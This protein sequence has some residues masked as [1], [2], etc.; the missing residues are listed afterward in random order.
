M[1]VTDAAVRW[2]LDLGEPALAL[3]PLPGAVAVAGTEGAVAVIGLD[4]AERLRLQ[5]DDLP[6]AL[7]ASPDGSRLALGGA[8]RLVVWEL[9]TGGRLR[10][11]SAR[12]CA[13]LAWAARSDRLAAGDGRRVRVHDRDGRPVWASDPLAST[14]AGLAWLWADGRRLAAAAYQGVTLLEP[15][16]GR[17]VEHLRAPGAIAGLA[18]APPRGRWVVGGSQDATLHGWKV[19][20]GDD[21]R[22]SGFPATV[23]R[24]AFHGDGRW[25]ACESRE[26]V[27][28]WDF[29]GRGPVGREA[30]V[31]VGHRS[32]IIALVWAPDAPTLLTV[33]EAGGLAVWRLG[34]AVR[35]GGR[36]RPAREVETAGEASAVAV[37]GGLVVV[38]HR[39][40][41]VRAVETV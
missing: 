32:P 41:T 13:T 10:D 31:G 6:L 22:M 28:F 2:S 38:G 20:G 37:A 15:S 24:I 18:V 35:P 19:P 39:S 11:V 5:V 40:G 34:P 14:V 9:V 1:T 16:T 12:W 36:I 30:V 29:S 21:F 27:T 4:G 25:L 33:D 8:E 3:E 23:S 17:V 26:A 7:A